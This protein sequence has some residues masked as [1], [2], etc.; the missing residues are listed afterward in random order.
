M[1]DLTNGSPITDEDGTE[2][3]VKLLGD[4]KSEETGRVLCPP[5]PNRVCL[6]LLDQKSAPNINTVDIA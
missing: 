2:M 3:V 5:G 4:R 1:E 6:A